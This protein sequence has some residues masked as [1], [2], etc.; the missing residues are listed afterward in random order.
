MP[1]TQLEILRDIDAFSPPA[2]DWSR[3]QALLDELW[4][5][6]S[7]IDAMPELLALFARYPVDEDG[8][9]VFWSALHGLEGLSGYEPHLLRSVQQAPSEFGVM[10]LGRL[11][12]ADILYIERSLIVDTLNAVSCSEF[13]PSRVRELAIE[14]TAPR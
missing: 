9:G 12:N 11:L 10:M 4:A 6:G 2:D 8:S 7:P 3:L 14:F 5:D 13:A 1:R